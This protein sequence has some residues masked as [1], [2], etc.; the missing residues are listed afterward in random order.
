KKAAFEVTQAARK[1]ADQLGAES[2][3]LVIGHD[4]EK[5]VQPLGGYGAKRVLLA[6][7]SRLHFYSTGAYAR[8][9]AEAAQKEGAGIVVLPASQMGKDLTPRVAAKLDAGAAA[10]CVAL[11]VE[12]GEIIA[13]RPVY[14]GKAAIDVRV[15][16]PVKVFSLR[17]NV[18]TAT[19]SNGATIGSV[20]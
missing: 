17:P 10:D 13:T 18:F 11:K 8:I 6:D 7:D 1:L 5:I 9:I 12:N 14:A 16:S 3:G 15:L 19:P 4:I 20:E 2:V